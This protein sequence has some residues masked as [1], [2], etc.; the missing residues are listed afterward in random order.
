MTHS[1]ASQ[2]LSDV[3][4]KNALRTL[5]MIEGEASSA[6][7]AEDGGILFPRATTE[8][9]DNLDVDARTKAEQS[10]ASTLRTL[11]TARMVHNTTIGAIS[12]KIGLAYQDKHPDAYNDPLRV[13]KIAGIVSTSPTVIRMHSVESACSSDL[14]ALFRAR[15]YHAVASCDQAALDIQ[16]PKTLDVVVE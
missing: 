3:F 16:S 6:E 5:R 10:V 8:A 14:D 11:F 7:I 2:P 12:S 4:A 1:S 9:L 15:K 13:I